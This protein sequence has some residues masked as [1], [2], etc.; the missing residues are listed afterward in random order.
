MS[1][2]N[3]KT[4]FS[5]LLLCTLVMIAGCQ[6]IMDNMGSKVDV[7]DASNLWEVLKKEKLV[8]PD[9][10]KSKPYKASQPHG[11]ISQVLH[12]TLYVNG[13]KGMAII[14]R[15]FDG[16]EVTL[17]SVNNNA[18]TDLHAITVMFKREEGYD[19]DNQDWFWA[20]YK[21]NGNLHVNKN[22]FMKTPLAGRVAKG[23]SEGC[24]GCHSSAP[25]GDFVFNQ[26][27]IL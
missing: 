5:S 26:N 24:I 11:K 27:I 16:P 12:Q 10:K 17:D 6:N 21:A 13:H 1:A 23:Q 9:A 7:A 25:G 2:L 15:N 4:I 8:G 14:E 22:N 20:K 19:E 18:L 3:M